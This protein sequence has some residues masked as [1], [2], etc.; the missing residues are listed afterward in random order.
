MS[1]LKFRYP[2]NGLEGRLVCALRTRTIYLF[3]YPLHLRRKFSESVS[4]GSV[5]GAFAVGRLVM[6]IFF[7]FLLVVCIL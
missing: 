3:L 2:V 5:R 6:V 7:L 4:S 1:G